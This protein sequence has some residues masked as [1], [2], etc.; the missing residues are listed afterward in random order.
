MKK[1]IVFVSVLVLA[2]GITV[3]GQTQSKSSS[4]TQSVQKQSQSS[5]AKIEV[6]QLPKAAQDYLMK[7]YPDKKVDQAFK[8]TEAS[9]TVTYLA[10]IGSMAIHF[11]SMGKFIRE[12]KKDEK[13]SMEVKPAPTPVKQQTAP[14]P[15]KKKETTPP[16]K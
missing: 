16:K 5:K 2:T 4:S 3:F 1:L 11:D 15:D 7:T 9:G 13:G 10:E 6:N 12:T 14:V 8:L